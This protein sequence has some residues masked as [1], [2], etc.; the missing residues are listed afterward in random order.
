MATAL[1]PVASF[2]QDS[3]TLSL[4][5]DDVALTLSALVAVNNSSAPVWVRL[6]DTV[7][8]VQQ[9]TTLPVGTTV[10]AIPGNISMAAIGTPPVGST[11]IGGRIALE[12]RWPA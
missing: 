6:T 4:R 9:T 7:T 11:G 8:H 12:T 1:L 10:F 5:Y 3:C 2:A